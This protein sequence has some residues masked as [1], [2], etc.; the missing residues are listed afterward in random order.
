M[1]YPQILDTSGRLKI[2]PHPSRCILKYLIPSAVTSDSP[3][4][5]LWQNKLLIC[6]WTGIHRGGPNS[7]SYHSFPKLDGSQCQDSI[8]PGFSGESMRRRSKAHYA[9]WADCAPCFAAKRTE[10]GFEW[11]LESSA[12]L[13]WKKGRCEE[14]HVSMSTHTETAFPLFRVKY[15]MCLYEKYGRVVWVQ[16]GIWSLSIPC[17]SK[18][19]GQM[20][21]KQTETDGVR[22]L[23]ASVQILQWH[24]TWMCHYGTHKNPGGT[25]RVSD[26]TIWKILS[27]HCQI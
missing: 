2:N 7:F 23:S 20:T 11:H 9:D 25:N 18:G 16:G 15:H 19:L 17:M 24:L 27:F 13:R 6:S 1:R 21:Q 4:W 5:R 8:S 10:H 14:S 3:L 22:L 26:M 12:W